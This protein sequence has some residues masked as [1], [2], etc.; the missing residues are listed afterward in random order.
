VIRVRDG[1]IEEVGI[2]NKF[3]TRNYAAA[4][5]FLRSLP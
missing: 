2:A 5:H 1:V 4:R 3:L